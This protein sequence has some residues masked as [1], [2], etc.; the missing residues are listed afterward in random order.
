MHYWSNYSALAMELPQSCAKPS[1]WFPTVLMRL[2]HW[3]FQNVILKFILSIDILG[4]SCEI[5]IVRW[6]PQISNNG[7]STL[8]QVMAWCRQASSHYLN[9]RWARSPT[10]YGVTKPQCVVKL[11]KYWTAKVLLPNNG[12]VMR[13]LAISLLLARS[14]CRTNSWI[15]VDLKHHDA[16]VTLLWW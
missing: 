4:V 14:N 10:P 11:S 15:A 12:P 6:V 2:D 8:V 3:D 13:A 1:I 5:I 7:K 16:Q 9:H